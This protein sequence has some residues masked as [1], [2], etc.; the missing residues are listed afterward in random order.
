MYTEGIIKRRLINS[1]SPTKKLKNLFQVV[2]IC[3]PFL[4]IFLEYVNILL[5]SLVCFSKPV[6]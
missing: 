1:L 3:L 5:D 6:N 4:N 2:F